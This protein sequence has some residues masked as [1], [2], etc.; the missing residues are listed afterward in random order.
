MWKIWCHHHDTIRWNSLCIRGD[1]EPAPHLLSPRCISPQ[2]G[3]GGWG[4]SHSQL[5]WV[6]F[7]SL[8][9]LGKLLNLSGPHFPHVWN[10][11]IDRDCLMRLQRF[12]ESIWT[13][14]SVHTHSLWWWL[15][16]VITAREWQ[17]HLSINSCSTETRS[18]CAMSFIQVSWQS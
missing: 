14:Q 10:G 15:W 8:K 4:L 2:G 11:D 5:S 18:S 9:N 16:Y 6:W 17:K 7:I 13:K 12:N 3:E 1:G